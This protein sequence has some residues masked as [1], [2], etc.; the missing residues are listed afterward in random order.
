MQPKPKIDTLLQCHYCNKKFNPKTPNQKYCSFD[1]KVLGLKNKRKQLYRKQK[2]VFV[3][4]LYCGKLIKKI[5]S[6]KYC[7]IQCYRLYRNLQRQNKNE[8]KRIKRNTITIM[9]EKFLINIKCNKR[10]KYYW[11]AIKDGKIVLKSATV[12]NNSLEA[13]KDID[14]A[15]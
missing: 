14:A 3:R 13:I 5:T 2:E 8:E 12:F 10:K 4:C 6:K 11:E 7:S 1:C 9:R 15:F